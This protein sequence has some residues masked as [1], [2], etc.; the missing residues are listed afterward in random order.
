MLTIRLQRT[1]RKHEP[2]FR[3]VLTESKNGP[4]SGK[5]LE[6]LGAY[7]PRQNNES[8]K[9][10]RIK[11]WISKGAQTSDTVHNL[12]INQK[13]IEGKKINV[14]PRKTPPAVEPK[15]E[16][17]S[18]KEAKVDEVSVTA[19]VSKPVEAEAPA[20]A[21]AEVVA[22]VPTETVAEAPTEEAPVEV[23]EKTS[24]PEAKL[25]ENEEPAEPKS[26]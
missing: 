3:V 7:D 8:L 23:V 20:E 24:E 2:T 10:E 19:E 1:G 17:S 9:A 21:L 16:D 26:E 5:F 13:V 6:I 12:L 22:E 18:V 25:A 15:A 11:H 4:K 14:L